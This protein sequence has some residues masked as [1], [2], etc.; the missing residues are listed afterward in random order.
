MTK[1]IIHSLLFRILAPIPYGTLIYLLLLL[2]NNNLLIINE[3]YI[4]TELFFCIGLTYITLEVNRLFSVIIFRKNTLATVSILS[5]LG[6]NLAITLVVVYFSLMFYFVGFLGYSSMAGF[7]NEIKYFSLFLGVTSVLYNMLS[8]SFNLLTKRN[9]QL[10]NEEETLKEYVQFELDNYQAQVNPDLLFESLESAI[11]LV[12]KDAEEAEDFIDHLALAYRYILSNQHNETTTVEREIEAANNILHL[13]NVRHNGLINFVS[14]ASSTEGQIIPGSI[15]LLVDE[16]IKSTL[17][18]TT[19]PLEIVLSKEDNYLTLSY[20]INERLKKNNHELLTFE[21]LHTAYS[22][23]TEEPLV[24][25][26]AYGNAFYKIP[27]LLINEA[28]A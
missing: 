7:S 25:V 27:L 20:K 26:L 28:A 13:H 10:F 14:N 16:I 1:N 2:I 15:P 5:Q 4:S 9:E 19:K 17:I 6:L 24:K 8:I 22:Y 18:S 3:S 23:Y 21:R 12:H 11:T